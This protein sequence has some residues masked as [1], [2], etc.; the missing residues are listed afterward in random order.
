MKLLLNT[1]FLKPIL[2]YVLIGLVARSSH[3][4]EEL[5]VVPV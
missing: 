2:M 4:F 1:E 5:K 3:I